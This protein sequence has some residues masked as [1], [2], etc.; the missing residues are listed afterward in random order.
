MWYGG[1]CLSREFVFALG[2]AVLY[3]TKSPLAHAQPTL[4]EGAR[5]FR[6][7]R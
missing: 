1:I 5:R 7:V 3:K 4:R 2:N 6:F